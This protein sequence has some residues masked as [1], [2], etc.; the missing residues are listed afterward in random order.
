MYLS[1]Q[2]LNVIQLHSDYYLTKYN[3]P[4]FSELKFLKVKDIFSLT[5]L[6][7]I[8]DFINK[9]VPNQCLHLLPRSHI[10]ATHLTKMHW[11][12]IHT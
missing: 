12:L 11:L 9:K 3:S 4:L 6:L 2:V 8:F 5:K 1:A 10:G 7:F